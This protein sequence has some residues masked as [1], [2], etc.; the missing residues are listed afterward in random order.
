[1][2][3]TLE[4]LNLLHG[5]NECTDQHA[6]TCSLISSFGVHF[7]KSIINKLNTCTFSTFKLVHV[8]EQTGL[9]FTMSETLKTGF[10]VSRFI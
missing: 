5:K 6:H 10:P 3:L 8:A 4:N 7:L 9:S 1:M 2:V